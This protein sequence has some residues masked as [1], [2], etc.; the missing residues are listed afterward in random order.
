MMKKFKLFKRNKNVLIQLALFI[1]IVIITGV[2]LLYPTVLILSVLALRGI[3]SLYKNDPCFK[4]NAEKQNNV[5]SKPQ[6]STQNIHRN[7]LIDTTSQY[8]GYGSHESRRRA[9]GF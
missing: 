6:K 5:I 4:Y 8:L 3:I 7:R 9:L 2:D 1:P